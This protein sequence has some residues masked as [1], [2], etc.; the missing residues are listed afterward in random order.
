MQIKVTGDTEER[1]LAV[2]KR[3][4]NLSPAMRDIG[5]VMVS[6]TVQGFPTEGRVGKWAPLAESTRVYK[7]KKD[8][9]KILTFNRTLNQSIVSRAG[10][11]SVEIGNSLPYGAIHQFGGKA[12][13]GHKSVIPSRP[14]L[15]VTSDDKAV[16]QE[17]L[18]DYIL[19][20]V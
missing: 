14:Y 18:N 9:T 6:R 2:Q 17:I 3:L 20:R 19:G 4:G 10:A 16:I 15:V 5:K 11:T 1:L 7:A 8:K 12:G 13:R